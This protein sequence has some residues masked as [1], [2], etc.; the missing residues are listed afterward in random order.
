MAAA[1]L[2][3]CLLLNDKLYYFSPG[4]S[5][6]GYVVEGRI[7]LTLGDPIGPAEDITTCI[8]SFAAFCDSNDWEPAYYQVLPDYLEGLPGSWLS[9]L[10]HWQEAIVNLATFSI[11]GGDKKNI[12]T[13]V[14]QMRKLGYRLKCSSRPTHPT[15][16]VS[17]TRSVMNG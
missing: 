2:L 14:N 8:T 17:C 5:V 6:V 16:W 4:G 9:T 10:V 13:G 15:Y 7:A 12:R 1:H 11:A 3:A